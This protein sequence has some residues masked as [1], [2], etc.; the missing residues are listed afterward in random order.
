M[1]DSD[2]SI[3][4]GGETLIGFVAAQGNAFELFDLAEEVLD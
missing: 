3:D 4:H 1:D 2:D